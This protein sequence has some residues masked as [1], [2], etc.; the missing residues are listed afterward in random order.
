[1]GVFVEA[2]LHLGVFRLWQVDGDGLLLLLY[3]TGRKRLYV[4]LDFLHVVR[5]MPER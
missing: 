1:M 3:R 4:R 2:T 5:D